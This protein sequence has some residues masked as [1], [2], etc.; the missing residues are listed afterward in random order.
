MRTL[1]AGLPDPACS[2]PRLLQ[3]A[4]GHVILVQVLLPQLVWLTCQ[5]CAWCLGIALGSVQAGKAPLAIWDGEV[6]L[7]HAQILEAC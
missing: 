2:W 1:E 3:K 4:V 5:R 7:P 6:V